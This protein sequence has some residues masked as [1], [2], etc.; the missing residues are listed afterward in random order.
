MFDDSL[1]SAALAGGDTDL[2]LGG[3]TLV[4]RLSG[5][6]APVV[7]N[8]IEIFARNLLAPGDDA[9][10][11]L[12]GEA[13]GAPSEGALRTA[14]GDSILLSD[15]DW[16]GRPDDPYRPHQAAIACLVSAGEFQTRAPL[17][18]EETRR[19]QTTFASARLA[20]GDGAFRAF[21]RTRSIE[22]Q[23][24][25]AMFGEEGSYSSDHVRFFEALVKSVSWDGPDV[26]ISFETAD[27][28]LGQ[29][30]QAVKWTGRGGEQGDARLKDR[31]VPLTFGRFFNVPAELE[32]RDILSYRAHVGEIDAFTAVKDRAVPLQW[33]GRRF[34]SYAEYRLA[35]APDPGFYTVGPG[36]FRLGDEPVGVVTCDG[37]G[38]ILFGAYQATTKAVLRFILG[39]GQAL[40]LLYD[41]ATFGFL[42]DD[43]IQLYLSPDQAYAREEV[44][45]A[46]LAPYLA[47]IDVNSVGQIGIARAGDP[48]AGPA[49]RL[50]GVDDILAPPRVAPVENVV[51]SSQEVTF[52]RNWRPMTADEIADPADQPLVS[53]ADFERLQQDEL[54][55][56][57]GDQSVAF[58]YPTASAGPRIRGY[59]TTEDGARNAASLIFQFFSKR[60]K[61]VTV[62]VKLF[63]ALGLARG[64]R[65]DV[66]HPD[67]SGGAARRMT[68][69]QIN[70]SAS[71][72][73]TELVG[74]MRDD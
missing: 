57:E 9:I 73:T 45:N 40:G 35:A 4:D 24:A 74:V 65:V 60:L 1:A 15:A 48:D 72:F 64:M 8:F 26:T 10:A 34:T 22:G 11:S 54:I 38:S 30:A 56:A 52:A 43:E 66:D 23:R 31:Y 25:V 70:P 50:F 13:L 51:R 16:C 19:A 3:R 37:R 58:A 44:C 12:G 28:L 41:E 49:A 14:G 6:A 5:G 61:F 18:P 17:Y 53:V 7:V 62:K 39:S 29:P 68:L 42:P 20:D 69:L 36:R 63:A 27:T 21:L 71:S 67:V 33:D 46:L 2:L 32:E 47:W 59:F 55:A